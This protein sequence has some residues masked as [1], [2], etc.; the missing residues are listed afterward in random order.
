MT[1][2]VFSEIAEFVKARARLMVVK[3]PREAPVLLIVVIT[4]AILTLLLYF[5]AIK[6]DMNA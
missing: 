5:L 2:S 4:L 1:P 3:A 6:L